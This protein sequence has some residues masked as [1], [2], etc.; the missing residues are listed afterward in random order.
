MKLQCEEE[1]IE[2]ETEAQE[3]LKNKKNFNWWKVGETQPHTQCTAHPPPKSV[4]ISPEPCD[5]FRT[6]IFP[7]LNRKY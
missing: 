3:N 6:W 4:S 5:P 7:I 1:D 2:W